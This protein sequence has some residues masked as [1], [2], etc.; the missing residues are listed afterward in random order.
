MKRIM[1]LLGGLILNEVQRKT[2]V[3]L[4]PDMREFLGWM[5]EVDREDELFEEVYS[6]IFK[7]VLQSYRVCVTL[8]LI[9]KY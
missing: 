3:S 5:L 9:N 6:I 4:S 1:E 8:F 7:Y 2:C